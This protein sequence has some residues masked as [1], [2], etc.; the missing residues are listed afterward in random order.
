[1]FKMNDI[2]TCVAARDTPHLTMGKT[3]TVTADEEPGIFESRPFVTV[4]GDLDRDVVCHSSRFK[5]KI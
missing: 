1:M 2:V 5:L 4:F 3:Y